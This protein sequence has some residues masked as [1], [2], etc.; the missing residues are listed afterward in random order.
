MVEEGLCIGPLYPEASVCNLA[1]GLA[2]PARGA[3]PAYDSAY[4]ILEG[5]LVFSRGFGHSHQH[6]SC[7]LC[8][9]TEYL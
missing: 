1:Y 4:A 8:D 6:N 9:G 2:H 7:T 5:V 3:S